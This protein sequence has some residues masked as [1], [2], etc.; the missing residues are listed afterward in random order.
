MTV[1][2]NKAIAIAT[3]SDWFKISRQFI[4]Q[5]KGKT[6]QIATCRRDVSR[7]LS[8]L[9]G[10]A[11]NLDWFIALFKPAVIGRSHYF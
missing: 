4:N 5:R 3:F 7:A 1:E 9:H 11:K 2:R 6:K 10:N 8:K